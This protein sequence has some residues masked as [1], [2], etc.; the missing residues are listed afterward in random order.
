[1]TIVNLLIEEE[2][3]NAAYYI[4]RSDIERKLGQ[5]ELAIMDV[6]E[7]ARIEPGNADH[8]TLLSILYKELGKV[9]TAG[10]YRREADRLIKDRPEQ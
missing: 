1:M 9:E 8:Y 2:P 7:A 4:A 10:K 6:E 5:Y 3:G